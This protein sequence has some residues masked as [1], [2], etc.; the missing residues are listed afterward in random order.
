MQFK[1][2]R[3]RLIF[4]LLFAPL[5]SVILHLQVLAQEI[6][7]ISWSTAA[8]QRYS[9]SE[10]QGRVVNGKLYSFGGFDSQKSTFT[11][12]K[13]AYVFDPVANTWT[14]IADLPYTPNGA[15]FGGVTH[16]GI[17]TDGTNI[18]IAGGY[19]SNTSGT[20]QIFGTKQVWKYIISQNTYIRMP[21][22]PINIAAG[23]LEY[24]AGK[25]HYI[26]GTNSART[27]DL[28]NHY[29]LDLNNLSGGWTTLASLPN[30][31][32][33][34][35]SAVYEG[36]IYFIGGQHG[37]DDNLV[38][39]KDVH[40]YNPA[41]NSWTKMADLPVPAGANGRG[42]ISSG[43]AILGDRILVLGG[44]I[45][46]KTS[47]NMVSAYSPATNSWVNLTPLPSSRFSGVAGVMNSNIYYTGGS[48][49]NTTYK[50]TPRYQGTTLSPIADA[51][52][53][54]GSYAAVN[55]G[56]DTS[57]IVKGSAV[58]NFTRLSYL[59]FSLSSF[60]NISSA[61]LR[62]YG[63]NMDNTTTINISSYGA[64]ND[65]WTET[66]ITFNSA[67]A[68]STATLSSV[69]VNNVAK[70]YEFDVTS[71]VKAQLAGDKIVTILIKDVA[72]QNSNVVFNSREKATNKPQ[73][74]VMSSQ[75][76]SATASTASTVLRSEQDIFSVQ[77]NLKKPVIYP[78]P[79]KKQ[80]TIKLPV[81]YDRDVN[82]TIADQT[83]R[84]YNL[85]KIRIQPGESNINID[86]S[87]YSL[88][89][90]VYFLKINSGIKS[91]DLKLI[92]Q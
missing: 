69:G 28:G 75:T 9:V 25:L 67:P 45:V 77:E 85:G 11:P 86:I 26:G 17:T 88:S 91:D 89:P 62:I 58:S 14:P 63:R 21:D 47:V 68:A 41:T 44:E 34:A 15:N 7:A 72:N 55:Y 90:G 37:Q 2:S 82:F 3:S 70:Y 64:N 92:V 84:I 78:N 43:V 31:R 12:T 13:R 66:G 39:Q 24:L 42:H 23:Q 87:N 60:S 52:V 6:T 51:F 29:V 65:S 50:G 73:L 57:L 61:K 5:L 81:G 27:A 53:R 49:T 20:G 18:Y 40:A 54:N 74:V 38:T 76:S 71:Y 8:S 80:F 59:K 56:R 79:V 48:R 1:P 36:K 30:P 16:A 83:G 4:K 32:N 22:L 46:H 33:H 19:T 10:A 35:G